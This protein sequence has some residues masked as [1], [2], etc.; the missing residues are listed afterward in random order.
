M[1]A[2]VY[3]SSVV[4]GTRYLAP[5]DLQQLDAMLAEAALGMRARIG[6]YQAASHNFGYVSFG[7]GDIVRIEYKRGSTLVSVWR[8]SNER[9]SDLVELNAPRIKRLR[10]LLSKS[11]RYEFKKRWA[12]PAQK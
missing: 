6:A 5:N 2:L 10:T 12:P 1:V 4:V 11:G 7:H 3:G 8:E 9:I